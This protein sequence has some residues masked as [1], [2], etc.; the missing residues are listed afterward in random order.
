LCCR[1]SLF[2][3]VNPFEV[4]TGQF[5]SQFPDIREAFRQWSSGQEL[6]V[7][8]SRKEVGLAGLLILY[9]MRRR[10]IR[11]ESMRNNLGPIHRYCPKGPGSKCVSLHRRV[12]HV[13]DKGVCEV[14]EIVQ[15]FRTCLLE[16][17]DL[18]AVASKSYHG[19][20]CMI[21]I[22]SSLQWRFAV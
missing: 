20:E 12:L 14:R 2:I 7:K 9:E 10:S 6:S 18:R 4:P 1:P 8:G 13:A 5:D 16:A 17:L 15:F 11:R 19:V 22:E 3:E 21:L